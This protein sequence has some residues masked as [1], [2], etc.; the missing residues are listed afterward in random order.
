MVNL[1]TTEQMRLSALVLETHAE[2]LLRQAIITV[3][4]A[5]LRVRLP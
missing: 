5:R 2:D 3:E 1:A 4:R